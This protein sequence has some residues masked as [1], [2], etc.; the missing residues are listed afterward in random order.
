MRIT[1]RAHCSL[2]ALRFL[3]GKA[4]LE[5][6]TNCVIEHG[7]DFSRQQIYAALDQLQTKDYVS[8][9]WVLGGNNEFWQLEE[10]GLLYLGTLAERHKGAS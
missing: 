8:F 6:I 1:T 4:T 5:R 10:L 7:M 3:G 2:L 9:V